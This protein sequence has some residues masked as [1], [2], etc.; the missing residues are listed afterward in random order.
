MILNSTIVK[1][2]SITRFI[3]LGLLATVSILAACEKKDIEGGVPPRL[4]RPVVKGALVAENN[5]ITVNWQKITGAASYTVELSRDTFK[6]VDQSYKLDSS[7]WT[8]EN[9][10]WNKLYQLRI[11]AHSQDSTQN[12]RWGSLGAI[13]TPKFP[14]ILNTPTIN[15]VSDEA[16]KVSWTNR[17]A[18]VTDIKVYKA[19]DSSFVKDVAINSTD[20]AN[21][22]KVVNGLASSTQYIVYLYSGSVLRGWDNYTTKAPLNGTLVDLR[23]V[24][25]RPSVL[26]DTLPFIPNGATVVLKRGYTYNIDASVNLDKSVIF[27]SGSDLT[28]SE[29][30]IIYFTGNFNLKAG[31]TIDFIDFSNVKL[32]GSDYSGK[33]VMNANGVATVGRISF[34]SCIARVFRGMVRLQTAAI[35][36]TDF[37]INDCVI[38]SVGNYGVVNVDVALSKIE[39]ISIKNSTIYKTEKIIS[40]KNNS[41]SITI[42]ACTFNEA[43]LGGNYVIAY[44]TNN[45]SNGIKV[46]NTIF[47]VGKGTTATPPVTAIRGAQYG[48]STNVDVNN[49]HKT[50]D[51]SFSSNEFPSLTVYAK[52]I[53]DLWTSPS[54]GNFRI[55]DN[56]FLT[57][58]AGDPRWR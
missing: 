50:S 2:I 52:L 6:T 13:K 14:T 32:V 17:G 41:T 38:D 27:T 34:E 58:A 45:V 35:T 24:T 11:M 7:A 19:S 31:S 49:S 39:N 36:V 44:G 18:A 10:E 30:A 4:F 9:L 25:D 53:T 55:K 1:T 47:G 20:L 43:P 5:S 54:T 12:S 3:F 40:S 33:Y 21:Q 8:F 37:T 48:T 56:S 57:K 51:M 22:Y 16:V 28:V 46:Y 29:P 42:D 15:D 23:S 26:K